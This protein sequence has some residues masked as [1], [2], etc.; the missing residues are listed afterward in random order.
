[1]A[2]TANF[3]WTYPAEGGTDWDT[4][5]N[6]LF[7]DA[8]SDLNTVKTTADAALAKAG[9][10]MTGR[11]D[12]FSATSKLTALGSISGANNVNLA[13]SDVFT[14]TITAATTFTFTNTPSGTWMTGFVIILT[15]AGTSVTWPA[16]VDWPGAVSPTLDASGVD[17]LGFLTVDSGTTWHGV[18]ISGDSR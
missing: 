18:L 2:D 16:S 10:A 15:N 5:L 7:I 1:M 4:T 12:L 14:A 17:I 13:L 11:V 6:T 3:G 9:G 8:D